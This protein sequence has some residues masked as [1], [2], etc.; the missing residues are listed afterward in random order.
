MA[1][2]ESSNTSTLRNLFRANSTRSSDEVVRL[3]K[4]LIRRR[5]AVHPGQDLFRSLRVGMTTVIGAPTRSSLVRR[6]SIASRY[7]A[8]VCSTTRSRQCS[9]RTNHG[10]RGP[11]ARRTPDRRAS[12]RAQ[13]PTL[14]DP[15]RHEQSRFARP[16]QVGVSARPRGNHWQAERHPLQQCERKAL[17]PGGQRGQGR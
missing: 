16:N 10:R 15:G 11:P 8:S 7:T 14:G 9:R 17:D 2:R 4:T 3:T 6:R 12:A 13:R 1:A 5:Y